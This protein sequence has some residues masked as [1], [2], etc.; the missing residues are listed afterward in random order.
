MNYANSY[1]D[2]TIGKTHGTASRRNQHLKQARYPRPAKQG[3]LQIDFATL[4][5]FIR[6]APTT[7]TPPKPASV[8]KP[9]LVGYIDESRNFYTIE[10]HDLL[11]H[12]QG[13]EP[14]FRLV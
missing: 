9:E 6:T 2:Y 1:L 12:K 14:V 11:L 5:D 8:F 3:S 7:P 13:F 10:Q 4:M